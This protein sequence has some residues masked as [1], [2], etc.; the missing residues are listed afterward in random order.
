[1]YADSLDAYS[2]Y[3][4]PPALDSGADAAASLSISVFLLV[5]SSSSI[6]CFAYTVSYVIS[7]S[8]LYSRSSGS[9]RNL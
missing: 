3:T 7:S 4:E 6:V 9:K 8:I 1:M 2:L 5:R